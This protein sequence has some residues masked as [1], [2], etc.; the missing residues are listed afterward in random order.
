VPRASQVGQRGTMTVKAMNF[1]NMIGFDQ[2]TLPAMSVGSLRSHAEY[3]KA[4]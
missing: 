4:A 2:N 3:F 1:G